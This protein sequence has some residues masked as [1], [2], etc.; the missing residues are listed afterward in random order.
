MRGRWSLFVVVAL[1]FGACSG[2]DTPQT[3]ANETTAAAQPL[4]LPQAE[5]LASMRVANYR[6]EWGS[7]TTTVAVDGRQRFLTG[8]VNWQHHAGS[9]V[10]L[11]DGSS[12]PTNDGLVQWDFDQVAEHQGGAV[13]GA[14]PSPP[15]DGTWRSRP[16][17]PTTQVLDTVLLLILNLAGEQ[18]DNPQLLMQGDARYLGSEI[19]DGHE[20]WELRGPSATDGVGATGESSTTTSD[21]VATEQAGGSIVYWIWEDGRVAR[22][23]AT[24]G[25]ETVIVSF[26]H[27][28][29]A[30]VVFLPDIG[31]QT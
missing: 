26:D 10:Y 16:I 31:D 8:V 28:Q 23:S 11:T 12:D 1:L 6:A 29:P 2:D 27:D 19:V 14:P 13:Q 25:V 17:D 21:S 3:V 30:P 9:L 24:L 20:A 18:A 22:F 4:S 7:F 5:R 15:E